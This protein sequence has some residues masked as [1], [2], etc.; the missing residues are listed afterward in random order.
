MFFKSKSHEIR[1]RVYFSLTREMFCYHHLLI[2]SAS[3]ATDDKIKKQNIELADSI[4]LFLIEKPYHIVQDFNKFLDSY[5][6]EVFQ[7]DMLYSFTS[8]FLGQ[9]YSYIRSK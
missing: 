9:W 3:E 2:Q 5:K 4:R 8:E 7:K 6:G 1:N